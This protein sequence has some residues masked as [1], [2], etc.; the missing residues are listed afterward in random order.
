MWLQKYEAP[1]PRA[2]SLMTV[3]EVAA[4]LAVTE[5]TVYQLMKEC[6]LPARW[7]GSGWRFRARTVD[8][9][10]RGETPSERK[11]STHRPLP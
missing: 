10:T 9:W 3:K 1:P 8:A 11:P 6:N 4:F 5:P 2:A 7:V